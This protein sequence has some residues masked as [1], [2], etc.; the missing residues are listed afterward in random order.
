MS[1]NIVKTVKNIEKSSKMSKN[2][3]KTVKNVKKNGKKKSKISKDRQKCPKTLKKPSKMSKNLEKASK[4]SK[5]SQKCR[6]TLKKRSKMSKKPGKNHQKYRKIVKNSQKRCAISGILS[7]VHI[8]IVRTL[9][10]DVITLLLADACGRKYLYAI[11]FE[12]V[13]YKHFDL[14]LFE[15]FSFTGVVAAI[16]FSTL[17]F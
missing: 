12:L 3:E 4:I 10:I 17:G 14:S 11:L 7:V 15:S 6:K 1:K 8:Y 2:A 5:N 13:K 16:Y 9:S